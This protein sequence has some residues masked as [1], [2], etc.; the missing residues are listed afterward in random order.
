MKKSLLVGAVG[1]VV[2]G[3]AVGFLA[4]PRVDLT[5]HPRPMAVTGDVEAYVANSEARVAD[6]VPGV[7]K[8]IIWASPAHAKTPLAFVYLHGF[9]ATR[10][11]TAPLCDEV[12]R[13]FG[14][15]LYYARLTGHGLPG[16]RL[17]EATVSDWLNDALEALAI[18]ER[19]GERVVVVGMSTGGTLAAWLALQR[20]DSVAAY[21]MLSPNFG[22]KDRRARV[23]TWPWASRFVPLL[24]PAE[25]GNAKVTGPEKRYWTNPY[26]TVALIPMMGLVTLVR[27]ARLVDVTAP[28]LVIYSPQDDRVDPAE[29]EY[30]FARLGSA[31]KALFPYVGDSSRSKHVIAGDLLAPKNTREVADL[32]IG[33]LEKLPSR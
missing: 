21:V 27:E 12:A 6:L 3:L 29:I 17:A 24:F 11:E 19:L 13:H 22:P 14:A 5:L 2:L 1:V 18:G 10:Q 26:P 28:V 20:R 33:F 7:E 9:S 32:I 23:L 16:A 30:A 25:Q 15:N 31:H 4:G 8:K